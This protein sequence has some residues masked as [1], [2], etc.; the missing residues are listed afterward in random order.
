MPLVL[1]PTINGTTREEYEAFLDA[2]RARRLVAAIEYLNAKQLSL[3]RESDV[4]QR[5]LDN[6]IKKLGGQIDRMTKLDEAIQTT[7]VQVET[8]RSELGF[9]EDIHANGLVPEDA[10]DA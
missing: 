2:V 6:A 8:Y 5:K 1:Q 9:L 3:D 4:L 10:E 7:L